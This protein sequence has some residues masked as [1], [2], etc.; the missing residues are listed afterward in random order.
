M[1]RWVLFLAVI[2]CFCSSA[3]AH[4]GKTDSNGGHYDR[5]TG[6]YH[7]HHG[8]P[9][10]K[11]TNG[12]CPYNFKDKTGE[13]S[14][15]SSSG[16]QYSWSYTSAPRPTSTPRRTNTPRPTSTLRPKKQNEP[17]PLL[18]NPWFYILSG[19]VVLLFC[20][21]VHRI[22]ENEERQRRYAEEC[23]RAEEER[24]KAEEER[25]RREEEELRKK[26][27]AEKER[28]RKKEETRQR[29][30]A[31]YRDNDLRQLSGM[32]SDIDIK[33]ISH[34]G[35]MFHCK[36]FS[37]GES[38]S[39]WVSNEHSKVYHE[40]HCRQCRY[41][42]YPVN[43]YDTSARHLT[44][45]KMCFP[46]PL[47]DDTWYK[48]FVRLYKDCL[49]YGATPTISPSPY[50]A[51]AT[52]V[53]QLY[54]SKYP[55]TWAYISQHADDPEKYILTY[56]QIWGR[57]Q[58]AHGD[59]MIFGT[60]SAADQQLVNYPQLGDDVYFASISAKTYHSTTSCY[61]LLKTR[62]PLPHSK[63]YCTP[64]KRCSKCVPPT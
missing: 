4:G 8:Y 51:E 1:R 6:E 50:L 52:K 3:S 36:V 12:K 25:K 49:S 62:N 42:T 22:H 30:V 13:G 45:C 56:H 16:S 61:A 28:L 60:L 10:H 46:P 17:V 24:R 38:I 53:L 27:E 43:P 18:K 55:A 37:A 14:G 21:A 57:L 64:Y 26:Q 23:R 63:I 54:R 41:G 58:E 40:R 47:P 19:A 44:P 11:H 20:F 35:S 15:S 59:G 39:I 31:Y 34:Y 29:M 48:E 32:P 33:N 9:A 5:S 2:L 7:Y